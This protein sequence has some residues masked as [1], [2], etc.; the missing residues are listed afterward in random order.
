MNKNNSRSQ[1]QAAGEPH[2]TSRRRFLANSGTAAACGVAMSSALFSATT[3]AARAVGKESSAT[4]MKMARDIYPHDTLEDKYYAQVMTPLADKASSDAD[5]KEM[6]VSGVSELDRLSKESFGKSYRKI[7]KEVDRVKILKMMEDTP[8]FQR[9]KG[10][11]MMGI[12]NNPEL[13]PRFGFGGS[14]VEYGG[15]LDRGYNDIDWL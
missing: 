11:L 6:L 12:Y 15:Y 7:S 13:W 4:L 10:D 3:W 14:A 2:S 9:I 1:T 5:L 8:F